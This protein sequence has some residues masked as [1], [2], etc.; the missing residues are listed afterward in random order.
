MMAYS[1]QSDLEAV[2]G[3]DQLKRYADFDEDGLVDSAVLDE[4]IETA[5]A[6]I[7]SYLQRRY[8]VPLSPV[9]EVVKQQS[10][11]IAYYYLQ[12]RR[13]A[14]SEDTRNAYRDAIAWCKDVARGDVLLGV[15][16]EPE[17]SENLGGVKYQADD[18]VFGRGKFLG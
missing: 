4:A 16:P 17:E 10:L 15:E 7:N 8:A 5:D 1:T 3:A 9:P 18:Q 12:Q 13:G 11:T 6:V 14:I 2:Y